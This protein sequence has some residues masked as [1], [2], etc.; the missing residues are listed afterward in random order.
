LT[1]DNNDLLHQFVLKNLNI[2]GGNTVEIRFEGKADLPIRWWETTFFPGTRSLENEPLSIDVAYGPHALG[3]RRY[4]YRHRDRT[5]QP[6][7]ACEHGNGRS[8][9][10]SGI[11][12][13]QRRLADLPGEKRRP[14]RRTL[15]KFSLTATQ[16]I[17][18]FDS[19]APVTRHAALPSAGQISHSRTDVKSRVY[20]YY[21][22]EVNAVARPEQLEVRGK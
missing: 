21:D 4:R 3:A 16:A 20:E 11:R 7:Q 5:E 9:Y 15:E 17:L 8:G 10:S 19:F 6:A 1:P 12:S 2:K 22:P 18:Y 14:K 13:A